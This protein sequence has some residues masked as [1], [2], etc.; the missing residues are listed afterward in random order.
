MMCAGRDAQV[1]DL[2]PCRSKQLVFDCRYGWVYDEWREPATIAH[3]GGRGMFS[4]VPLTACAFGKTVDLVNKAADVVADIL[5]DPPTLRSNLLSLHLK[6]EKKL[7]MYLDKV[8]SQPVSKA[9][10]PVSK[11]SVQV[12]GKASEQA[13]GKE[14]GFD[15]ALRNVKGKVTF[16]YEHG[17]IRPV[18]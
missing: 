1:V 16:K 9:P 15:Q 10:Q 8:M 4:I 18:L 12:S 7:K 14:S 2:G 11:A 5:Q 3:L 6:A 17:I 13:S